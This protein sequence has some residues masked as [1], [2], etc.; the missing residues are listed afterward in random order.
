MTRYLMPAILAGLAERIRD[1]S[2]SGHFDSR[3]IADGGYNKGG[4]LHARLW[5]ALTQSVPVRFVADL[6]ARLPTPGRAEGSS[7]KPDVLVC[8]ASDRPLLVIELASTNSSDS[9]VVGRDIDRL[10]YL[11]KA[12]SERRPLAALLLTVLPSL[13]MVNLPMYGI[14]EPGE[15]RRRRRNPYAFHRY[16]YLD[17]LRATRDACAPLSVAWANVDVDAIRL[18]YWDGAYSRRPTWQI[19]LQ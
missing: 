8:G 9:R 6:E 14:R 7:Y 17:A 12:Q 15:R 16:A 13:P 11:A 19:G 2:G 10:R 5:G 18:E 1:L 3:W 4:R